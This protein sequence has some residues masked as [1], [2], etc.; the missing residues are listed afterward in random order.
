MSVAET[1]LTQEAA[2]PAASRQFSEHLF[3]RKYGE[4]LAALLRKFG[5][6]NF[7]LVEEAIQSSFLRALETWPFS[8][9]PANPAGWLFNVARNA[10][11][12][13]LRKEQTEQQKISEFAQEIETLHE[14]FAA[15]EA[16]RREDTHELDDLTTMIL[17]CCNPELSAKA[18]VCLTL[19]AACGFSVREIARALGA[20]EETVK[21]TITRAKE[22]VSANPSILHALDAARIEERFPFV[23]ETLYAMFTEGYSAS[24]GV[25]QLRRDIAEESIRLA[26]VLLA[27]KFTPEKYKGG[28]QALIALMLLQYARFEARVGDDGVP[29]RLQEQPRDKWNREIIRAGLAAL[30][31]SKTTL[32]PTAY[33]LEAR[34]AAEHV[35]SPSFAAT[36]WK[37]I[38]ALYDQ[39]LVLKNTAPVRLNR[40]VALRYAEGPE[41]ALRD[42]EAL[43]P[44]E[45]KFASSFLFHAVWA[46]LLEAC[47]RAME[48][49]TEW[50]SAL[51]NAPTEAEQKFIKKKL[52]KSSE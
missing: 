39:L 29:L 6:K 40:I 1:K 38:L 13:A 3:R 16:S 31:T 36:D 22:K 18:Q 42:L 50:K 20:E 10:A 33:H 9:I 52:K 49:Q 4:M 8:G 44:A 46:D 51:L 5:Y 27:G 23:M 35:T 25:S 34:I 32:V 11:L 47:G 43:Q 24:S 7:T 48:A 14:P 28:L 2:P 26:D 41:V 17:L 15:S 30:E 21:K 37:K 19:K 45:N 12:D